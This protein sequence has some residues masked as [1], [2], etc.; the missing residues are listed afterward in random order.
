MIVNVCLCMCL[1]VCA[2]VSVCACVCLY[3]KASLYLSGFEYAKLSTHIKSM[4]TPMQA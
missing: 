3:V 4:L 1:C 2:C